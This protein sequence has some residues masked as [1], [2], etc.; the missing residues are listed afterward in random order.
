MQE[1]QMIFTFSFKEALP[2]YFSNFKDI[3]RQVLCGKWTSERDCGSN[4]RPK[5]KTLIMKDV[6][7]HRQREKLGY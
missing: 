7:I 1:T 4:R 3:P 5:T 2:D 6:R